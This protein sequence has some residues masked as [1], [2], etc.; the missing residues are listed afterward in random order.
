MPLALLLPLLAQ[1][2]VGPALPQAPLPD[3]RKKDAPAMSQ[4]AAPAQ[5]TTLQQCLQLAMERP[6]DAIGVAD[7][8]LMTAKTQSDRAQASQCLG[9]A[10]TRIE[11]WPVAAKSFLIA[12][13]N[14][15][16]NERGER[17]RLG[18]L[19]GNAW[20]VA[21][22]LDQALAALD[23]AH[24]DA[25]AAGDAKLDGVIQI[26]RARTLVALGRQD[27]AVQAL[28][29]ARRLVPENAQ[30]WL[31]SATLSRRQGKLAEAQTQI[32]RAS[33]LFPID[34]EIG[35]EAGVIAV[36]SGRDEA[37][38]LSWLSVIKTAPGSPAAKTAQ[39]YLDQLGP[40][41]A[42]PGR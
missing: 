35:L 17:G 21:G 8:W 23:Q 38:R 9:M 29:E 34:P 12:R 27:E 4:S 18:A 2:G 24:G 25:A 39:G 42:Q 37:A 41:A 40:P 36:L 19:A 1:V 31:L 7:E 15:P 14:T 13:D 33:D 3:P 28:A 22:E 5:P 6:S 20:F 10:M 32:E 26:D 16:A 30:A 11:A